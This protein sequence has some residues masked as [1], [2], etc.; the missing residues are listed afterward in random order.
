[1]LREMSEYSICRSAIGWTAAA[2]RMVSAPTSERPMC[3]DVAGLHQLGETADGLLD[4]YVW[5]EPAGPVDVDIV[6]AEA[7][8]RIGER[9]L[10][11][12]GA[13]IV[14]QPRPVGAALGAVFDA[15]LDLAAVAAM[16]RLGDQHL[17]VA[18]G[19]IVAGVEQGDA[20]VERG[21]DGGDA[22]AA[23]GGAVEIGRHAHAA[24]AE[25]GNR[26]SGFSKGAG[27]HGG[28]SFRLGDRGSMHYRMTKFNICHSI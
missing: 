27:D 10:G 22:L 28:G 2:R 24:E 25:G 9:R 20:G 17:V 21:V 11:G 1:M 16:K 15:D 18:H 3:A 19:V 5:I 7:L 14:A 13:G 4:R 12:C 6:G 23:V 26:G 8:Q